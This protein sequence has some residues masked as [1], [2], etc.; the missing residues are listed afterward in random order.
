MDGNVWSENMAQKCTTSI[1]NTMV[2][3]LCTCFV[4]SCSPDM[5]MCYR[6]PTY[7][8]AIWRL[9]PK[10]VKPSVLDNICEIPTAIPTF[11]GVPNTKDTF[12]SQFH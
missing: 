11:S 9:R 8:N 4:H 12:L 10:I 2:L 5:Q 3:V 1:K 7:K 6:G